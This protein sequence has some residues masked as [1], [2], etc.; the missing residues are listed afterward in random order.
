MGR[1]GALT[2][3]KKNLLATDILDPDGA[4]FYGA[5]KVHADLHFDNC[6]QDLMNEAQARQ[7]RLTQKFDDWKH[8]NAD[9]LGEL[10]GLQDRRAKAMEMFNN[11]W[12]TAG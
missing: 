11:A 5:V 7:G 10:A 3:L 8:R 9:R 2:A 1:H 12:G 6:A 4:V